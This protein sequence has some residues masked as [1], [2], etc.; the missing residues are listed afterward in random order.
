MAP[1]LAAH[2]PGPIRPLLPP[3]P[4]KKHGQHA[5]RG[6]GTTAWGGVEARLG[7]LRRLRVAAGHL[8][9]VSDMA[10]SMAFPLVKCQNFPDLNEGFPRFYQ[11]IGLRQPRTKFI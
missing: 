5:S 1:I 11:V 3:P 9:S 4:I 10:K 2:P 7:G 8:T 6:G